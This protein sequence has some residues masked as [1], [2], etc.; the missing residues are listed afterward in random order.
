MR[1]PP[2]ELSVKMLFGVVTEKALH[3][4]LLAAFVGTRMLEGSTSLKVSVMGEA[5]GGSESRGS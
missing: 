3:L 1:F 4:I 2:C 5:D